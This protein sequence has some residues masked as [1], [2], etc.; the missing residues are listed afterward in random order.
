M[1]LRVHGMCGG[2]PLASAAGWCIGSIVEGRKPAIDAVTVANW[3][4]AG[5]CAHQS[6]MLGGAEVEIPRFDN[7]S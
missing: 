2:E 6:A 4:A 7:L 3:T 5:I 1:K